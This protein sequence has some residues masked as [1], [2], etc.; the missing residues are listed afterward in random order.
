[1]NATNCPTEDVLL[2]YTAGCLD[3]AQAVLFERHADKCARC[4]EL[5]AAQAAVWRSLDEWKP[6]PVGGG[7]NRELWR[8]IDADAEQ[9]YSWRRSLAAATQFGFWKR[10]APLAVAVALVVT[11]FMLDHSAGRRGTP[12]TNTPGTVVLTASEADQLERALDDIQLLGD[13]DAAS[14]PAKPDSN[15]M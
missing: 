6:A 13:V 5:R 7:F 12:Q 9:A 2:D 8:K 3:P 1:M 10:A 11:G 15:L 14:A 4:A